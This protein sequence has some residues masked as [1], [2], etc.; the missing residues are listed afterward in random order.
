MRCVALKISNDLSVF[1]KNIIIF[2]D[3]EPEPYYFGVCIILIVIFSH[4][5]V[6]VNMQLR[7]FNLKF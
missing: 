7:T 3:M 1:A 4:Q 6:Y 5:K 2:L